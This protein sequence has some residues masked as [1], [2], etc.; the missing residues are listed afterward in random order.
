MAFTHAIGN[1]TMP[2]P[3]VLKNV[4]Q[5]ETDAEFADRRLQNSVQQ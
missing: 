1:G 2:F 5:I 3:N 4:L